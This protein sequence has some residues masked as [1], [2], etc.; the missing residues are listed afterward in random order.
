M[1]FPT[2]LRIWGFPPDCVQPCPSCVPFAGFLP[3]A[4]MWLRCCP[5]A[6]VRPSPA[7]ACELGLPPPKPTLHPTFP[8]RAFFRMAFCLALPCGFGVASRAGVRPPAAC[9][10]EV[11]FPPRKPTLRPTTPLLHSFGCLFALHSHVASVRLRS[12]T[13]TARACQVGLPPQK[14]NIASSLAPC[15]LF[16]LTFFLALPFGFGA[17]PVRA[18]VRPRRALAELGSRKRNRHLRPT[19]PLV[20]SFC[21]LCALR[22]LVASDFP[23]CTHAPI[24]GVH[25]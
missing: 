7:C 1:G 23:K 10:C 19:F 11:Q 15:A 4:P 14:T 21:C 6:G 22:S 20:H 5:G 9:A 18:C 2:R 24:R 16:W 3:R 13:P 17:T 25:L 12:W 8:P